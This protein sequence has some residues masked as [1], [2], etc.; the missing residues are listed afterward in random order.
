MIDLVQIRDAGARIASTVHRTPIVG[1]RTLDSECA[2]TIRLKLESFQKTGSFK[3]RGALN[4]LLQ[5]T[6]EEMERGLVTVSAGNHAQAAAFVC[7][8]RSIPCTVVMPQSAPPVKIA[9]VRDYGADIVLHDDMR[10]LFQQGFNDL[11][12]PLICCKYQR[13][14]TVFICGIDVGF[15]LE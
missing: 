13:S 3:P 14:G 1:S 12:V 6:P 7:A 5:M 11:L 4:R 15:V 9:A 8:S 10:T 2:G